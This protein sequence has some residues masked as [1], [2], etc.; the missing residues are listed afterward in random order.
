MKRAVKLLQLLPGLTCLVFGQ[1]VAVA[2]QFDPPSNFVPDPYTQTY[3]G[4][5]ME[6]IN[7]EG[8]RCESYLRW[9]IHIWSYNASFRDRF[10]MPEYWRSDSFTGAEGAG[11]RVQQPTARMC[12]SKENGR[13]YPVNQCQ[14]DFYFKSPNGV[15]ATREE[16]MYFDPATRNRSWRY[17]SPQ[18]QEDIDKWNN[19]RE[20][21]DIPADY[22]E[23]NGEGLELLGRMRLIHYWSGAV[24]GGYELVTLEGACSWFEEAGKA[25]EVRL[26]LDDGST[27]TV[28]FPGD[29]L[30]RMTLAISDSLYESPEFFDVWWDDV[31]LD[32]NAPLTYQQRFTAAGARSLER[33]YY[34][35]DVNAWF[36]SQEFADRFGLPAS[37]VSE[38]EVYGAQA[39]VVR[40]EIAMQQSGKGSK[41]IMELFMPSEPFDAAWQ[42]SRT[43]AMKLLYSYGQSSLQSLPRKYYTDLGAWRGFDE[44]ANVGE[45][46]GF[47]SNAGAGWT[48]T[49]RLADIYRWLGIEVEPTSGENIGLPWYGRDVYDSLLGWS[50]IISPTKTEEYV[51]AFSTRSSQ[52]KPK[53]FPVELDWGVLKPAKHRAGMEDYYQKN[54]EE[55]YIVVTPRVAGIALR[56]LRE[57]RL[58]AVGQFLD[59]EQPVDEIEQLSYGYWSSLLYHRRL[60]AMAEVKRQ[61]R[62]GD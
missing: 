35:E 16:P 41:P 30:Q 54:I 45:S 37:A 6:E 49:G 10:L 18:N 7:C 43:R 9:D 2:Q 13:C 24:R 42:T 33:E 32:P 57:A 1:D 3:Y 11:F 23:D 14:I 55:R 53:Y 51:W 15:L 12:E 17:F 40:Y 4:R 47:F 28:T 29:F 8:A 5:A 56:E 39:V 34:F 26:T 31:R 19:D 59:K 36:T 22:Y 25:G 58:D 52:L 21:F 62:G 27:K 20:R 48:R 61:V 44:F 50:G 60:D 46:A 38:Q